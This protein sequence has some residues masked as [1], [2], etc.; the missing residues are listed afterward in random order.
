MLNLLKKKTRSVSPLIATILLV[1][2]AV[3]LVTVVLTWGRKFTTD[4]LG[5]SSTILESFKEADV[6]FYLKV[7][8]SGNGRIIVDYFP[9][10]NSRLQDLNL[11]GYG[12]L[13][14]TDHV[15]PF[16]P[17]ILLEANKNSQIIDH[18]IML[19]RFD[20][21]LYT[22]DGYVITKKNISQE[23]LQPNNCPDGYIPV[24]GNYLYDTSIFFIFE[25]AY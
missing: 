13:G 14:Y 4:S 22:E 16:E 10:A 9:P 6:G 8:R 3:I 17:P 2:V 5:D 25:Y 11:I 18:G 21:L 20:L 24:P 1:V 12:L 23:I 7:F 15:V 19:D